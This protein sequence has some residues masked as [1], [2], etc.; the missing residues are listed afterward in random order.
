MERT[1]HSR[2][3]QVGEHD[4]QLVV[5]KLWDLCPSPRPTAHGQPIDRVFRCHP[6]GW[7]YRDG[8]DGALRHVD[9]EERVVLRVVHAHQRAGLVQSRQTE[10]RWH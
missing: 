6:C 2:L 9:H 10:A 3:G 8:V 1:E 7:A 5:G 4:R